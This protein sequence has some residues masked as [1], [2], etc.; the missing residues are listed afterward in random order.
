MCC[1]FNL[2]DCVNVSRRISVVLDVEDPLAGSYDLEVSSP[3][4]DRPLITIKDYEKY[5]GFDVFLIIVC[6]L[7]QTVEAIEVN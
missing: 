5:S 1:Q 6:P 7:Y 2:D 4:I 3:G